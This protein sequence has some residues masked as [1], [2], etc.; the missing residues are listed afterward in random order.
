MTKCASTWDM[1]MKV[2]NTYRHIADVS[3]S[4]HKKLP[5][6]SEELNK[7]LVRKNIVAKWYGWKTLA[8]HQ[9]IYATAIQDYFSKLF[10]V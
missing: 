8:L 3:A 5:I 7:Q 2:W 9:S 10:L 6:T 4:N 1:Q